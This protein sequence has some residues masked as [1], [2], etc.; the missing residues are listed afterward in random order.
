[1]CSFISPAKSSQICC[2]YNFL[3]P[4]S[5]IRSRTLNYDWQPKQASF[6]NTWDNGAHSFI[7]P[8]VHKSSVFSHHSSFSQTRAAVSGLGICWAFCLPNSLSV[9]V[10]FIFFQMLNWS[11]VV[12]SLCMSVRFMLFMCVLMP[13][14]PP[15]P[16]SCV[17]DDYSYVSL[18]S[19]HVE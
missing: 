1:M 14:S 15:A 9:F 10:P 13:H 6:R 17:F 16:W 12:L 3:L 4:F 2:I 7:I 19:L 11:S 5:P 18:H 8:S